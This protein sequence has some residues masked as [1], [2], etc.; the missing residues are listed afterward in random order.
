LRKPLTLLVAIAAALLS[1]F[2][3]AT[4]DPGVPTNQFAGQ[5]R[6]HGLTTAQVRDV[7]DRVTEYLTEFGGEQ[8]ALNKVALPGGRFVVLAL[9]GE[10]H[11]RDLSASPSV[12]VA[13]PYTYLCAYKRTGFTGDFFALGECGENTSI[14]WTTTGSYINNQTTGTVAVFHTV[15]GNSRTG[16]A[17]YADSSWNWANTISITPC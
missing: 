13:C 9:P 7:Q 11:A 15:S 16:P 17:Y 5:A 3:S 4:A 2:G 8:V 1:F 6:D 12:L 14:P 10:T